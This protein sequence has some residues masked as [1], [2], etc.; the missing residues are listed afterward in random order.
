MQKLH[1]SGR[2]LSTDLEERSKNNG[3]TSWKKVKLHVYIYIYLS[4]SLSLSLCF[5]RNREEESRGGV[6]VAG[7]VLVRITV[8]CFLLFVSHLALN[9]L[10]IDNDILFFHFL[11]FISL[12]VL[13]RAE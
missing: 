13:L 8:H 9:I 11:R 1:A 10:T 7:A 5:L 12:F 6:G 2:R 4:I 3:R